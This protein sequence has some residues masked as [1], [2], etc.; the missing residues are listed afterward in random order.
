MV[1]IHHVQPW[2]DGGR[3]DIDNAILCRPRHHHLLHDGFRATGNANQA[4]SFTRPD[5]TTIAATSPPN[6]PDRT[7]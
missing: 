7:R 1:D 5:R 6:L 2:D 3:T 4:V